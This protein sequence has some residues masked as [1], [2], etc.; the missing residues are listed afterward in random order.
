[1]IRV[2]HCLDPRAMIP[3]VE[4][5][6]FPDGYRAVATV[7]TDDLEVAFELT[8]TIHCAWWENEGV[9]ALIGPCRSSSVGDVFVKEDN[10]R[11]LVLGA[12]WKE[13]R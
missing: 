11:W 5:R 2:F 6:R 12:E 3:G 4:P 8:N 13:I 1:M 9:E 10:S 7:Q